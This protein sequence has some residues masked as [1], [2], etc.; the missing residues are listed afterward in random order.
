[1]LMTSM[2]ELA[3]Q[4][5]TDH[6]AAVTGGLRALTHRMIVPPKDVVIDEYRRFEGVSDPD[7]M[8]ILYA[9]EAGGVR[10]TL[11]DAF[12]VYADPVLAEVLSHI[13]IRPCGGRQQ[14]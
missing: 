9:V 8:A 12:G 14:P 1:M 5:F 11:V 6:F 13:A 10:G 4:G 7:D 2:E 3:R